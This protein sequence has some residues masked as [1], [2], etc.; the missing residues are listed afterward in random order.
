MLLVSQA[1]VARGGVLLARKA[2]VASGGSVV[3]EEG[4]DDE[5][6]GAV[7]EEDVADEGGSA[8]GEERPT[9]RGRITGS[10]A[11]GGLV[12]ATSAATS[13]DGCGRE[14]S[15]S[16]QST[17]SLGVYL[18][19]LAGGALSASPVLAYQNLTLLASTVSSSSSVAV[20][21]LKS[22]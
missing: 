7:G 8:V 21:G 13:S 16:V 2:L 19:P 4:T 15:V 11:A 20:G 22:T 3:G 12:Q 17:S 5:G 14:R 9:K 6:G 10:D 18:S 1:L